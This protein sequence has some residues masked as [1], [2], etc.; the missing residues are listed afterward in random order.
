MTVYVDNM[1]APFTPDHAPTRKYIMCHMMAD[2]EDEMHAM[3]DKIGVSRNW[4]QRVPSGNHYDITK[5]K[6]AAAVRA[7]A[8]EITTREMAAFAWHKRTLGFT[9]CP[10]V[11]LDKMRSA[12]KA[13]GEVLAQRNRAH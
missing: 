13:K 8:V 2:T 1:A 7:G 11:A 6:R 5:S 4:F 9:C 10:S 12:L 3:A